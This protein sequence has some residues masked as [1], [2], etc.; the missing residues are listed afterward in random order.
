MHKLLERQLKRIYGK[1]ERNF[2]PEEQ[3]LFDII[4]D[5]YNEMSEE[6]R[7]IEHILDINSKELEAANKQIREKNESLHQLVV[8][9]SNLLAVRTEENEEVL[10]LLHQYQQAIDRAL[11]VSI[12]NRN[13]IITYAN[14]N[15][16]NIS[17]YSREEL[18]G[19][20]HNIVRHP[21]NDPAIF[22]DLWETI[23]KREIWQKIFPNRAKNGDTYYVHSTIIPLTSKE[24]NIVE[25]MS[26]REDVTE[27]I[28]YERQLKASQERTSTILNNQE[29]II[30]ITRPESGIVEANRQFFDTFGY[31]DLDDF[32]TAHYCVCE[33]F[34]EKEGYL[35]QS[36]EQASWMQPLI[37]NPQHIHRALMIDISGTIRTYSVRMKVMEL[38]G[39][40][41]Y[42]TTFTD[43][44]ELELAR[45]NA[46]AAEKIKSEFLANMSHEIR[47]PMNG[48]RGFIQLLGQT[49]LTQKQEKYVSLIDTS[50]NTLLQIVNDILDFSKIENGKIESEIVKLNPFTEFEHIFL[51]LSEKA[52]EKH[53]AYRIEIDPNINECIQIDSVRI[54]QIMLNLIGNAIKFTPEYGT[55]HVSVIRT[56][57][58]ETHQSLT[59][60][61]TD[62]GI[63]IAVERQEKIFE[64]FSQ[65]D[66][67]TTR[68]FGGTGLGLSISRSLVQMMGGG[69]ELESKPGQGSRFF[70]TIDV[71]TC[72]NPESL[73][74]HLSPLKIC[75]LSSDHFYYPQI[76]KQ[77]N[78]FGVVYRLCSD[79]NEMNHSDYDILISTDPSVLRDK[80]GKKIILITE[81]ITPL[82]TDGNIISID[83]YEECPSLLY[84]TLLGLQ[85]HLSPFSPSEEPKH[86]RF[87]SHVLI[88]EDY[89]INR[90]L[91]SELFHDYGL[92]FDFAVNGEEAV[93][94]SRT[95]CYDLIF[96]D[97]NM[98][99][100]N[101]IDATRIIR[102]EGSRVPII[103]LT[104]NALD[105]DRER[106]LEAGMDEYLTKPIDIGN[107]ER[108]LKQYALQTEATED[109]ESEVLS[110][111][112]IENSLAQ[113]VT[114]MGISNEILKRL[115]KSYIKGLESSMALLK[116]GIA[117]N[118]TAKIEH[119][120]HD[121][122]SSSSIFNLHSMVKESMAIENHARNKTE[123]DYERGYRFLERCFD[124]LNSYN[125]KME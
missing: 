76:V 42:L 33:L 51:L 74:E 18:V 55:V 71:E 16:C 88:A 85:T 78:T 105:G 46:E 125:E 32:K 69:L 107:L 89:E 63:G 110:E 65:A 54:K 118:D 2:S 91:M 124:I 102:S 3:A 82:D 19:H 111:S 56:A 27:Q 106:F 95:G 94:R 60:S 115:F 44:T 26:I 39:E 73:A 123:Y 23:Q 70:F 4:S 77:L 112:E 117:T 93:E 62:T 8:E 66:S 35:I 75:L 47:T 14:D 67:S 83:H 122:K 36:T 15:F 120:V 81:E 103:A 109:L 61:V 86:K 90:M 38:D 80:N 5:T 28:L 41:S 57:T 72:K 12:T 99:V 84:N 37:D 97:I 29:S 7:L 30:V 49:P 68:K 100:M 11:I 59:F 25:Y 92:S 43:I 34:I 45:Q 108:I 98:P 6:R 10:N 113:T 52:K 9:R 13:G 114:A 20:S 21:D 58:A 64:P 87:A 79:L 40:S 48:I 1:G 104:A 50:T 101:G 119:G 96:M 17:G 31:N 121:I 116:E 22:K 24:G 53:L